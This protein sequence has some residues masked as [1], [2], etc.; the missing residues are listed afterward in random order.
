MGAPGGGGPVAAGVGDALRFQD[1]ARHAVASMDR[2]QLVLG[3]HDAAAEEN[4][5]ES[6]LLQL[7]ELESKAKMELSMGCAADV[8]YAGHPQGKRPDALSRAVLYYLQ[9]ALRERGAALEEGVTKSD[10]RRVL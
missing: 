6:I 3:A 8:V 4:V 10:Q 1:R 9:L 5:A 7:P 2:L